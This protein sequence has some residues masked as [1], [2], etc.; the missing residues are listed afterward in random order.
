MVLPEGAI[1]PLSHRPPRHQRTPPPPT[2]RPVPCASKA[3]AHTLACNVACLLQQLQLKAFLVWLYRGAGEKCLILMCMSEAR[4]SNYITVIS[5]YRGSSG[6]AQTRIRVFIFTDSPTAVNL[7]PA[8][9]IF[10]RTS[11]SWRAQDAAWSRGGSGG[12]MGPRSDPDC[13]NVSAHTITGWTDLPK[14]A[15]ASPWNADLALPLTLTDPSW[16]LVLSVNPG[17]FSGRGAKKKRGASTSHRPAAV[18]PTPTTESPRPH[19]PERGHTKAQR[20]TESC[21]NLPQAI[22]RNEY[23][24]IPNHTETVGRRGATPQCYYG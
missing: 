5:E 12:M 1:T 24:M 23:H 19:L 11:P 20:K 3:H 8:A 10:R 14:A 6:R 21:H 18:Q 16:P 22:D 2:P 4:C 13:L 17:W 7:S 15:A 9:C